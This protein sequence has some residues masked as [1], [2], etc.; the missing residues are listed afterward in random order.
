MPHDKRYERRQLKNYGRVIDL[1]SVMAK[2]EDGSEKSYRLRRTKGNQ[3]FNTAFR[4]CYDRELQ[5]QVPSCRSRKSLSSGFM[6]S[7]DGRG[8][9]SFTRYIFPFCSDEFP[10]HLRGIRN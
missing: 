5:E 2:F 8:R 1:I 10:D 9:W 4:K 7:Y 6:A 3:V